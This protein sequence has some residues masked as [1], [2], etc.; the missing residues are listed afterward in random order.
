MF[1]IGIF[2]TGS[3]DYKIG[4]SEKNRCAVCGCNNSLTHYV[5]RKYFHIFFI[6]IWYWGERHFDKC[7]NCGA[8]FDH[9]SGQA[10]NSSGY[11]SSK[12]EAAQS[13]GSGFSCKNCGKTVGGDSNEF[14]FCPYCGYS[15]E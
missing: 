15:F 2:G 11:A 6:P 4:S 12:Y 3:K 14:K 13:G 9:D 1:F 8:A 10:I 7:E 5:N